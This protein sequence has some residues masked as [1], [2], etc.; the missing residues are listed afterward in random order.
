MKKSPQPRSA[1]QP[2]PEPQPRRKSV[3]REYAEAL[4]VAVLLALLI[5]TFVVQA[6][7]IPS[8]SMIPTLLV[9]DHVLVA[10]FYYWFTEPKRG[11]IMVFVSPQDGKT[12]LIKRVVGLP[13]D[14]L[15]MSRK[16]V[17]IN[18]KPLAEPYS[19]ADHGSIE[20]ALLSRRDNF[21]PLA[22]PQGKYFMMGDNRDNSYDSRYWGL[23]DRQAIVGK[24]FII[25][26]SWNWGADWLRLVRWERFANLL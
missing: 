22:I 21:G 26:W 1:P 18:G 19:Q 8:G 5:R 14:R 6:F 17:F 13:G 15:S 23:V 24:A 10:K 20:S 16:Q 12:D 11:D 2:Q 4:I 3:F 25:Y 9:G 7:N